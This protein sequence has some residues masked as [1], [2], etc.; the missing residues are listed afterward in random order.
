MSA[1]SHPRLGP[2]RGATARSWWGKAW[3]RAV[4]EA[5]YAEADLRR[6]RAHARAGEVGSVTVD[7]GSFLAAVLHGDDAWAVSGSVPVLDESARAALV[8]VVRAES[9]RVAALLAGELPIDLVEQA[10]EAGVELLPYGGELV[11]ACSCDGWPDPCRHALAVLT[12][13][14][15]LLDADPLVL[16]GLRGLPRDELLAAVH[17]SGAWAGSWA[18]SGAD[19]ESGADGDADVELAL[20]AALRAARALAVLEEGGDPAHLL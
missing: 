5:A 19:D 12:V 10:E 11:T 14:G 3:Q 8:E 9:G 16:L 17:A 6:G 1:T 4:E 20:D 15:W 18:R 2:R 7:A 13:L